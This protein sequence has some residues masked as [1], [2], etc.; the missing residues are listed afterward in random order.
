MSLN[1]QDIDAYWLQKR[2]SEAYEKKIDPQ[3][4][5]KLFEEVLKIL[6]EG[7]DRG[8]ET[9]LLM[10]LQFDKFSLIK[11]LLRNRL[12]IV[13]PFSESG[14]PRREGENR[15]GDAGFR[16]RFGCNCTKIACPKGRAQLLDLVSLAQEE[17][18]FLVSNKCGLP[19][20]SERFLNKGYEEIHVP[21]LKPPPFDYHEKLVEIS[22]LPEWAQPAFK[23]MTQLNR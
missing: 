1:V 3:Q 22:S 18:R 13:H 5:Q 23:G 17:S 7:D 2:I 8:V 20:G 14:R 6:A 21:R 4:C 16:S 10:H 15:E 12:K 11:I 19:N 9:R